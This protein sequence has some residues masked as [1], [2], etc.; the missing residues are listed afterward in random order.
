[1]FERRLFRNA[2]WMRSRQDNVIF[3]VFLS[4]FVVMAITEHLLPA[5]KDG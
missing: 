1:M 2:V 5:N 4:P 3:L